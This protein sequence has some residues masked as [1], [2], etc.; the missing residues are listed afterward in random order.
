MTVSMDDVRSQLIR[1]EPDYK[2]AA[3]LGPEAVPYLAILI[4]ED[5]PE[6]A[7]NAVYLASLIT[8]DASAKLV[9]RAARSE[10]PEVR[11]AAAAGVPNLPTEVR[12]SVA[13][14][15]LADDDQ[16]VRKLSLRSLAAAPV[17]D[18]EGQ[19]RKLSAN[20]PEPVLRELADRV[21]RRPPM[22]R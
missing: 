3:L 15:L 6:L 13:G 16:G 5:D 22:P 19:L 7:P 4:E 21:V 17:P 8:T 1:D 9:A 20:D 2:E 10:R 12:R 14:I 18:L 11:L